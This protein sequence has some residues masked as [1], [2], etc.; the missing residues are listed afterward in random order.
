MIKLIKEKE[1]TSL[2]KGLL[3]DE[4]VQVDTETT[5]FDPHTCELL[6]LQLGTSDGTCQ[7]VIDAKEVNISERLFLLFITT[8]SLI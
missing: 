8:L 4:C 1:Q 7:Y 3:Q 2:F 6:S 5:G